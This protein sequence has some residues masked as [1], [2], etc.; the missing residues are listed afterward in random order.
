MENYQI[1]E[2]FEERKILCA[3]VLDDRG[4]RLHVLT[5]QNREVNLARKRVVH[6]VSWPGGAKLSRQELVEQLKQV[7]QRR[8]LLK[9][10]I[11]LAE[12][13]EL[14]VDEAEPLTTEAMARQWFG[15]KV[16]PDQVAALGRALAEDRFYFKH[17][18]GLWTPHPPEVVE[19]LQEQER[20]EE[21]RRQE[22][23]AA[24]QWLR[25]AWEGREITDPVWR[26]KLITILKEMAIYGPESDYY[27]LG[28][29][30]LAQ[31][32]LTKPEVPFKLLV[33]LGV[34]QPDENLDLYR[35]EAPQ[36]FSPEV[37]EAARQLSVSPAWPDPC[38]GYR[39]DLTELETFTIDGE[40]TRD[41]DDALSLEKTATGYRLGIHIADV[42]SYIAKGHLLDQAALERGTSLYL[43]ERRISMLPELLSENTFSL[44]ENQVR[45]ALSF[46]VDLSDTGQIENWRITP[47]LIR[48]RQRLTYHEVDFRLALD[49]R[50][51]ILQQLAEKLR[52]QRLDR[53]GIQMQFP[54]V[55][56]LVDGQG[57]V[58]I[59]IEDIE[60]PSHE[61]VS[62]AMI[63]ANYLGAQLLKAAKLPALYR[64]QA[65][66]RE[67]LEKVSGA[68]L[69]QLWQN[70]RRLSRVLLDLEPQPHWGLGL[71]VYTT[72]SSPIR[73]YLD[74]LMQRQLTAALT[75]QPPPYS[76][77]ELEELASTLEGALRRAAILKTR[78]LRYWLIKYLS[79]QLGKKFPAL[80]LE[81]HPNRYRLLLTD[82]LLE[83][84]MPAPSGHQFHPGETIMI[85]VDRANPQEDL[86]K[87][88]LA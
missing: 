14:L 82:I 40:R 72:L 65:P 78:R 6:A 19:Q 4:D 60:T 64:C 9:A 31:A 69:F 77:E 20:R 67:E 41:F 10:E 53:G 28:Q 46:L 76:R 36:E 51:G 35:Y 48:V 50:F 55:V 2:F 87:V 80:V 3:F 86:L 11:K 38:E 54:E 39:Q 83:T 16:T 22:L 44:M 8:E 75:E 74:L 15:D 70:R 32:K 13:W 21:A 26:E 7:G 62:E 5:E 25:E 45:R 37:Q 56:V 12:V 79:Q 59:E 84:D 23:A 18:A 58:R 66:P 29:E 30:Y 49:N 61:I 85:Q 88:S 71:P 57:E 34:F 42:S 24:G 52:Q 81:K 63:L 17:K 73:R 33:K 68:S 43:P 1:I 47:S 27:D